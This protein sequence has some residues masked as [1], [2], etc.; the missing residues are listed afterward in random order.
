[1]TIDLEVREAGTKKIILPLPKSKFL[2]NEAYTIVLVGSTRE[3]LETEALLIK[4]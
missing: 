3:K 1:M 4:D 2:P